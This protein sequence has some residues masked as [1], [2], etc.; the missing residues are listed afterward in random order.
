MPISEDFDFTPHSSETSVNSS[1][2]NNSERPEEPEEPEEPTSENN[3]RNNNSSDINNDIDSEDIY[4]LPEKQKAKEF[5]E[6]EITQRLKDIKDIKELKKALEEIIWSMESQIIEI[7][8]KVTG[9]PNIYGYD[10]YGD[11][12]DSMDDVSV[13]EAKWNE[14]LQKANELLQEIENWNAEV[15]LLSFLQQS[16]SELFKLQNTT[17]EHLNVDLKDWNISYKDFS[18]QDN[19]IVRYAIW[20]DQLYSVHGN[21]AKFKEIIKSSTTT[22]LIWEVFSI[23]EWAWA[24]NDWYAE[25]QRRLNWKNLF[26]ELDDIASDWHDRNLDWTVDTAENIAVRWMLRYG[27]IDDLN[28]YISSYKDS[29]RILDNIRSQLRDSYIQS[30][31]WWIATDSYLLDFLSHFKKI[32]ESPILWDLAKELEEKNPVVNKFDKLESEVHNQQL[33]IFKDWKANAL[34]LFDDDDLEWSWKEYFKP[35][36][37]KFKWQWYRQVER[38]N[39]SDMEKVVLQ[40]WDDKIT[41]CWIKNVETEEFGADQPYDKVLAKLQD[42]WYN[43]I[44]LRWHCYNTKEMASALWTLW[45]VGEW[46]ILIDWWCSNALK[47]DSYINDWVD[48]AIFAYTNTWK[49]RTTE[50]LFD[51]IMKEKNKWWGNLWTLLNSVN[52]ATKSNNANLKWLK[53]MNMPDSPYTLFSRANRRDSTDNTYADNWTVTN[54]L[55]YGVNDLES[56]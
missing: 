32:K 4:H 44:A 2:Q 16:G 17:L 10:W 22:D 14:I 24:F 11:L 18:T 39:D 13:F 3:E 53:T 7:T 50:A 43:L 51:L 12:D 31:W 26:D 27:K 55:W 21:P 35:N 48:W 37:A 45:M 41:L 34:I 52:E 6:A 1:T 9:V 54:S 5:S 19:L 33:D 56:H 30:L 36:I 49:W 8:T 25:I 23:S 42:N 46:D 47:V 40:K 28:K 20:W 15:N 38:T 29:Q